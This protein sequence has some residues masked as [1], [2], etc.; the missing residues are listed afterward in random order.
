[1]FGNLHL[2]SPYKLQGSTDPRIPS[3]PQPDNPV[4]IR[5]K[6]MLLPHKMPAKFFFTDL[7]QH[8]AAEL[9][10]N[11]LAAWK[12]ATFTLPY[13]RKL[14]KRILAFDKYGDLEA[15]YLKTMRALKEARDHVKDLQ[16]QL[17]NERHSSD[18][19]LARTRAIRVTGLRFLAAQLRK[20]R[21]KALFWQTKFARYERHSE[22]A[23]AVLAAK[24]ADFF[25]QLDRWRNEAL[26]REAMMAFFLDV[27]RTFHY[28]YDLAKARGN[29]QTEM[30]LDLQQQTEVLEKERD[31][32]V[33]ERDR[34]IT[35]KLQLLEDKRQ[36]LSEEI[37]MKNEEIVV[38]RSKLLLARSSLQYAC[39]QAWRKHAVIGGKNREIATLREELKDFKKVQNELFA[40]R[41]TSDL[42]RQVIA[43]KTDKLDEMETIAEKVR[44]LEQNLKQTQF[45]RN[46]LQSLLDAKV[47]RPTIP[48]R[49]LCM[50]CMNDV[51]EMK[52]KMER[53]AQK[54][55]LQKTRNRQN[56]SEFLVNE[57]HIVPDGD[58]VKKLLRG[59]GV[60]GGSGG[61]GGI[62]QR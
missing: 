13:V 41:R 55:L 18:L 47:T 34:L 7:D 51:N 48:A 16:R 28:K 54:Q 49:F 26:A 23:K 5:R 10:Q 32:L 2:R 24:V 14:E 11:V 37:P 60:S 45:E 44:A 30:L 36:L 52:E 25:E 1:M 4:D 22:N 3:R 33:I 31:T 21:R 20:Y 9:V 8:Q 15:L 43:E 50:K 58:Y 12:F 19:L 27:Y 29:K 57:L 53:K 62:G 35:E 46:E 39:L 56:A 17:Q 59:S 42:L 38:W 61:G 40:E 6:H